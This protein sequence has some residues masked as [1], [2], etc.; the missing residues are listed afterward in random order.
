LVQFFKK[1]Y[2]VVALAHNGGAI[3]KDFISASSF[4]AIS[5]L[6]AKTQFNLIFNTILTKLIVRNFKIKFDIVNSIESRH[7]LR[8][9]SKEYVPTVHLIHEVASYTNPREA[10]PEV[11][12][13]VAALVRCRPRATLAHAERDIF[14]YNR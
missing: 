6:S 9:L 12:E 3:E 14:L 11:H 2:N 8:S 1:K 10:F 13:C 4:F 7:L 5:R